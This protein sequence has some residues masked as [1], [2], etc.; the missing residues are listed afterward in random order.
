MRKFLIYLLLISFL[1]GI[2]GFIIDMD[3]VFAQRE[4]EI[5]Y[6][7]VS[8]S[9]GLTSKS[10]IP[11]YV[12]YIFNF[13]I[14]ASG[15]LAL[16]VLVY[17]GFEYLTSTGNVEKVRDAKERIASALL[18]LLILF[19]SYLILV[20]I[21]PQ[22]V[23][24]HIPSVYPTFSILK[25]GV[26]VCK[27]RANVNVNTAWNLQNEALDPNTPIERKRQIKEQLKPLLE[28]IYEEQCYHVE[29]AGDIQKSFDK[30]GT[31]IE[32]VYFINVSTKENFWNY[33]AIFYE[34]KNFKGD[35]EL[36]NDTRYGRWGQ[37]V[38]VTIAVNASSVRPFIYVRNPEGE[39]TIYEAT[40]FNFGERKA[41][42]DKQFSDLSPGCFST[43]FVPQ[44]IEVKKDDIFV[45]LYKTEGSKK[46]S[47][48]F[49][50]PGDYDLNNNKRIHEHTKCAW[51]DIFYRCTKSA[52]KGYCLE[53]AKF[54]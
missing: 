15:F 17:G 43:T 35:F 48:V 25:H 10:T 21:N 20:S 18:G 8:G 33:G 36:K 41:A 13:A 34:E 42:T 12:K 53:P 9:P 39:A 38:E 3:F 51:Y 31:H 46:D 2:V 40:D 5:E 50:E 19:G 23:I 37:I 6:P 4:L 45:V 22:L 26:L 24:F 32:Y 27:E 47:G 1:V 52:V 54:Y 44:S 16:G 11:D 28:K 14:W 29:G 30:W 49:I 7:D